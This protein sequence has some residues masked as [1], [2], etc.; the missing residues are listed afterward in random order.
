MGWDTYL[1][2]GRYL[3]NY[4]KHAPSLVALLFSIE[5]YHYNSATPADEN[6]AREQAH[7]T[8][9]VA[10][11]KVNLDRY[12]YSWNFLVQFYRES[13]FT[14]AFAAGAFGAL[15]YDLVSDA[16]ERERIYTLFK[17][18]PPEKDLLALAQYYRDIDEQDE[19]IGFD[20]LFG[21]TDQEESYADLGQ[22]FPDMVVPATELID[23]YAAIRTVEFL[24]WLRYMSPDLHW[25]FFVRVL[26]ESLE[27][28]DVVDF[29]MSEYIGEAIAL[30]ETSGV[31]D[32]GSDFLRNSTEGLSKHAQMIGR[33]YS[34]LASSGSNLGQSYFIGR[35]QGLL[36]IIDTQQGTSQERGR[37][38]ED[39]VEALIRMEPK[40]RVLQKN[41]ANDTEELDI[42]LSN[43]LDNPFWLAM[44]S[45]VMFVECK[46]WKTLVGASEARVFESKLRERGNI[47]RVGIFVALNG[48]TEPF[49]EVV[50][51]IQGQGHIIFVVTGDDIRE[52]LN[53]R[54]S[55]PQWLIEYGTVRII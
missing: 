20:E 21:G 52:M 41:L 4:R 38:L 8:S 15:L 5:D 26:L 31:C 51:R 53:Q 23:D 48:F 10:A 6:I 43:Q 33:M 11:C 2:L 44:Q 50:R 7:F 13:R 22:M 36:N 55:L 49:K 25:L 18:Y 24:N 9:T 27:D 1:R 12:G 42:V 28:T 19:E 54:I 3:E 47:C 34:V 29:D 37:Y 39:L 46:N 14:E 17:N 16:H 30:E 35:A 40:L 32:L 45:P